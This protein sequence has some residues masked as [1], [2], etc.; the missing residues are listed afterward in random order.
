V[1]ERWMAAPLTPILR[2]AGIARLLTLCHGV[3][4]G[5]GWAS[6]AAGEIARVFHACRA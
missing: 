6:G 3:S 5:V 1:G 2:R 4:S